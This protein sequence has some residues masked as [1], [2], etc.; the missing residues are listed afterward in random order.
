MK[1]TNMW[2]V[3]AAMLLTMGL[4]VSAQADVAEMAPED[5]EILIRLPSVETLF[6][7]LAVT[8]NSILGQP[9]EDLDEARE[10][11]GFNPLKLSE[12]R[13][14]GL[15][16]SQPFGLL[17]DSL[18]LSA[19]TEEPSLNG[20]VFLPV[21]DAGKAIDALKAMI[22]K[23]TPDMKWSKDGDLTV[24]K[25]EGGDG[26]GYMLPKAGHLFIGAAPKKDAK[27][28]M[29]RIAKTKKGL[30]ADDAYEKVAK[31]MPPRREIFAYVDAAAIVSRNLEA[32]KKL[33]RESAG[34]TSGPDMTQNLDY[35]KE[36][37]GAGAG[38]DFDTKD[39]I[40]D[41]VINVTPGA[42]SL[43]VMKDVRF[44][45]GI[46]MGI[47]EAP[48]M[49]LSFAVNPRQYY[50]MI[51]TSLADEKRQAFQNNLEEIKAGFGVDLVSDVIDNLAGNLN[52]GIYDG[53]SINMANYNALLSLN[54]KDGAKMERVIETAIS[55]LPPEQQ[56]MVVKTT[57]GAQESYMISLMGMTQL[58]L[59]VKDNN[60]IVALGKPMYEKAL[61]ADMKTGFLTTLKDP[62]L[63]DT[64]K[65]DAASIFYL[66]SQETFKAV[67]NFSALLQ[68]FSKDP[69][70][71]IIDDTVTNAVN[72]FDYLLS[73]SQV[74]GESIFSNLTVKTNFVGSFFQGMQNVVESFEKAEME[75]DEEEED[76][77]DDDEET[78]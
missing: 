75:D 3:L 55:K 63:V 60:L 77:D 22:S 11:L 36:W 50:D 35:L 72:Q 18:D 33:S 71:P 45:K 9:I 31:Q 56:S 5:T 73:S 59:G 65:S 41:S 49:L 53:L 6:K 78:D 46:V 10:T 24:F 52:L 16:T 70:K 76:D 58:F 26:M 30:A 62:H 54:L 44:D 66:D 32:I 15:D 61:A 29:Q 37:T 67:K 51:M 13:A 12:L 48:V 64:L 40:V 27:P 57:V 2:R 34:E 23:E 47:K 28:F 8:E 25:G 4:T 17:V 19:E 74:D 69:S 1:K 14:R 39:L 7:H 38:V 43:S 42:K 20:A 68:Q 21:T